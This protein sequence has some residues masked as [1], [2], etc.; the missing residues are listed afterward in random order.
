MGRCT[1]NEPGQINSDDVFYTGE[2]LP[3]LDV[4]TQTNLT[5]IIEAV[6]EALTGGGI[7][8]YIKRENAPTF[9]EISPSTEERMIVVAADENNSGNLG[10]YYY[11]NS[12]LTWIISQPL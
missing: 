7:N 4:N 1:T 8:T 12:Q 9:A 5:N 11:K 2:Y 3:T 10:L 6:E